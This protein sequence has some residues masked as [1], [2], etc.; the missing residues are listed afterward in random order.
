MR[1]SRIQIL[2]I[3]SCLTIASILIGASNDQNS[4]PI[5]Y[6]HKLHVEEADLTCLDCHQNINTLARASIPNISICGDCHDDTDSENSEERKVAEY[7]VK[8]ANIPWAQVHKIPDHAYFSHR[9]HVKLA[10]IECIDCHGDVTQMERPF[11]EAFVVMEMEWCMDC[12]EQLN[13]TND[14]SACHR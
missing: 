10:Q 6:N 1:K 14:C 12:H 3:L 4:Q 8:G 7:V 2:F 11:I 13:V 5:Q 9:R